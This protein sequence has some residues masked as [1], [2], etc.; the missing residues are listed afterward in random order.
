MAKP[1]TTQQQPSVDP[2]TPGDIARRLEAANVARASLSVRSLLLLGLVGGIYIS[3]G[4]AL[5]T[6]VLTD[7]TLGY[8]LGRLAAGLAFSLGLIMLVVA[9]GELFTGN[10]LMVLALAGRKI[11]WGAMLR[12]WGLVYVANAAGAVLLALAIHY[13]G[14]LDGNGVKAT[15]VKIAEG[16]ARLD[17]P[18]AFL[19]GVLCN[20]LVCVAVWLSTAARSVEGKVVA[21]AFPI[22]AF[23]ALGFEHCIANFYLLGIGMLSGADVKAVEFVANIASVTAGNTL[24][25]ILLAAIL[26]LIYLGKDQVQRTFSRPVVAAPTET[27]VTSPPAAAT[28]KRPEPPPPVEEPIRQAAVRI[29]LKAEHGRPVAAAPEPEPPRKDPVVTR[30]VWGARRD[31]RGGK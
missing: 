12:N 6:L 19:R 17:V 21:I 16:K 1:T 13:S 18:T 24:G 15:A 9:G 22:S 31:G 3:F 25:G 4:G 30:L 7:N 23:V 11:T 2:F 28:V 26:F 27:A 29:R 8:G 20:M 10:N 5:A 14:I